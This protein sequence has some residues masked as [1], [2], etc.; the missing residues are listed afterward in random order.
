MI[1]AD[2]QTRWTSNVVKNAKP[3]KPIYCLSRALV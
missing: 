2:L 3:T 1:V